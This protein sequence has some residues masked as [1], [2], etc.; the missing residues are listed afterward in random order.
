MWLKVVCRARS[1]NDKK[2]SFFWFF[3]F[4]F[5][6]LVPYSLEPSFWVT[7]AVTLWPSTVL[8]C[9][10]LMALGLRTQK[11]C[12]WPSAGIACQDWLSSLLYINQGEK[13]LRIIWP[14]TINEAWK[15][16][17]EF[18]YKSRTLCH[19][20]GSTRVV[21]IVSS[22]PLPLFLSLL[23]TCSIYLLIKLYIKFYS[24]NRGI[25]SNKR[26]WP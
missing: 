8:G 13:Q 14:Q 25:E 22:C 19:S 16:P 9:Y 18:P 20:G 4:F 15:N 17:K 23:F 10:N 7:F 3:C 12:W 21:G 26:H 11:H 5:P 24:Q 6:L 2:L 1:N